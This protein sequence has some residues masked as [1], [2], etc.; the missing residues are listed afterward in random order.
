MD[1][2]KLDAVRYVIRSD[3]EQEQSGNCKLPMEKILIPEMW[4]RAEKMLPKYWMNQ[5]NRFLST[6]RFNSCRSSRI[7]KA[8]GKNTARSG[9]DS[10]LPLYLSSKIFKQWIIEK[11][12]NTDFQVITKLVDRNNFLDSCF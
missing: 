11:L 5:Q 9:D 2:M 6:R 1:A 3:K 10:G 4:C 8:I 7:D 12:S